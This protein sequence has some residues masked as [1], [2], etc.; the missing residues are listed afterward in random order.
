M[1]LTVL[2]SVFA[3]VGPGAVFAA[4][5]ATIDEEADHSV[6]KF[7]G[8]WLQGAWSLAE[9]PNG[10]SAAEQKDIQS[11]ICQ[12]S[13]EVFG[14]SSADMYKKDRPVGSSRIVYYAISSESSRVT[15]KTCSRDASGCAIR[16]FEPYELDARIVEYKG[17]NPEAN[18]GS[19]WTY[20]SDVSVKAVS[21]EPAAPV[22]AAGSPEPKVSLSPVAKW[23]EPAKD[24]NLQIKRIADGIQRHNLSGYGI[25]MLDPDNKEKTD[26]IQKRGLTICTNLNQLDA[27]KVIL[28]DHASWVKQVN[29][30]AEVASKAAN[31]HGDTPQDNCRYALGDTKYIA[32]VSSA[33]SAYQRIIGP[34]R[35]FSLT[36]I[37][38]GAEDYAREVKRIADEAQSLRHEQVQM[39]TVEKKRREDDMRRQN[40]A[41]ELAEQSARKDR[42]ASARRAAISGDPQS[43][44]SFV[45]LILYEHTAEVC[46]LL[47]RDAYDA[48]LFARSRL[49][50]EFSKYGTR[51]LKRFSVVQ[52]VLNH[53]AKKNCGLI[54]V[55]ASMLDD[56]EGSLEARGVS[57]EYLPALSTTEVNQ[58]L[59][60]AEKFEACMVN[61]VCKADEERK[62][63][64]E[65]QRKEDEKQRMLK[66]MRE[67]SRKA[68]EDD[69]KAYA[70]QER[71][72]QGFAKITHRP[73]EVLR[74]IAI[75]QQQ[76]ARKSSFEARRAASICEAQFDAA[77]AI[78]DTVLTQKGLSDSSLHNIDAPQYRDTLENQLKQCWRLYV[79]GCRK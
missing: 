14:P 18:L 7:Q 57:Y 17:P 15:V 51:E 56:L 68:I 35:T 73:G 19:V 61:P 41:R 3:L 10:A 49:S 58:H 31:W 13:Y 21:R 48:E 47:R 66:A 63:V 8:N 24:S 6:V 4:Q 70:D 65:K 53:T 26:Y 5:N 11:Q 27:L 54:L 16:T 28:Q 76:C 50:K 45:S 20:C 64:A 60:A 30:P 33:M 67:Q 36:P 62:M 32:A 72:W 39:A 1:K 59:A 78:A 52:E 22:I 2:I 75:M 37:W 46:S 23:F 79:D 29:N 44:H 69:L 40:E 42:I 55:P 25:L 74:S 34:G 77:K 12:G 71:E 43:P 9:P 38:I